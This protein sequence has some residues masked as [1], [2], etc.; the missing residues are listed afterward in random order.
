MVPGFSLAQEDNKLRSWIKP[1]AQGLRAG[2]GA[3][4]KLLYLPE[5][6]VRLVT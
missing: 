1:R 4:V 6:L 5:E 3:F 2:D